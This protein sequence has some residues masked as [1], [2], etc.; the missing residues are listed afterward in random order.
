MQISKVNHI[1]SQCQWN[2]RLTQQ[3]KWLSHTKWMGKIFLQCMAILCESSVPALSVSDA[4]SG[5]EG[6]SSRKKRLNPHLRGTTTKLWKSRT[7]L[8]SFG[9]HTNPCIHKWSTRPLSIQI[10]TKMFL[11]KAKQK[12]Y[13]SRDG[14]MVMAWK[15]VKLLKCSYNSMV[16]EIGSMHMTISSRHLHLAVKYS[17]GPSGSM[18][19][20]YQCAMQKERSRCD[21]E[22]LAV[23]VR[24]NQVNQRRCIT[25]EVSWTIHVTSSASKS[26]HQSNEVTWKP[27]FR[28]AWASSV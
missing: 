25:S 4:R 7:L 18:R 10:M 5:L 11:L 16:R 22:L 17:P 15:E 19:C 20:P 6:W 12:Q 28:F 13:Q 24:S 21:A 8:R 9:R 23:M 1:K 2:L 26:S 14:R 3:M 27:S